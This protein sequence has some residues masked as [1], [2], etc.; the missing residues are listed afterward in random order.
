[1]KK[2]AADWLPK[3]RILHPWPNQR[4]AV[5]HPRWEPYAGI[6]PVR[7]CAGGRPVMGVPTAIMMPHESCNDRFLSR[8]VIEQDALL[9]ARGSFRGGVHRLLLHRLERSR[10]RVLRPSLVPTTRRA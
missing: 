3:A 8:P 5:K 1:M 10:S 9:A 7:I 4:F 6:P 2:L